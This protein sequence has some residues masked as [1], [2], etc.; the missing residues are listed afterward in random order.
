MN[1]ARIAERRPGGV[2][3]RP[4]TPRWSAASIATI[5]EPTRRQRHGRVERR[6]DVEMRRTPATPAARR[7]RSE[8]ARR[9]EQAEQQ[10]S[11]SMPERRNDVMNVTL[12]S[13]GRRRDRTWRP[14]AATPVHPSCRRP[15][16]EGPGESRRQQTGADRYAT[17]STAAG[18]SPSNEFIRTRAA[19]RSRHANIPPGFFQTRREA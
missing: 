1:P 2:P 4:E 3:C 6:C 10:R 14:C 11:S 15:S 5:V 18:E 9:C 16:R 13:A 8:H 7:E 19:R 12:M 17:R